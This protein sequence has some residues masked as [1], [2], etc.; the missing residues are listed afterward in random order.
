MLT[1][2]QAKKLQVTTTVHKFDQR[3]VNFSAKSSVGV[4]CDSDSNRGV[5]KSNR[6]A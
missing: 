1:V 5:F 2:N 3:F 6:K 4:L